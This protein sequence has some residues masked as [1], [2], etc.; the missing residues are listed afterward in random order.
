MAEQR[1]ELGRRIRAARDGKQ[2]K[3]KQLAAAVHVEP[4][5][6][7]RWERGEHAPDIDMLEAIAKATGQPLSFFVDAPAATGGDRIDALSRELEGVR[8]SLRD[9][10]EL[11]ASVARIEAMLLE[12]ATGAR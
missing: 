9:L 1:K 3:Q 10:E 11:K 4:V 2:W 7:S 6:V 8:Q 12:R 5:T